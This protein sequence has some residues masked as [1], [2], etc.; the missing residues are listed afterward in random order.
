MKFIHK[1]LIC[2]TIVAMSTWMLVMPALAESTSG[3]EMEMTLT[4]DK[5][6]YK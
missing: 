5:P 1:L 3:N 4:T 2:L 6:D